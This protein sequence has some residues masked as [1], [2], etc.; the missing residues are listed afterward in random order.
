MLKRTR[1]I[2]LV[3]ALL[4]SSIL[5]AA[6]NLS[7][8]AGLN[9][10]QKLFFYEDHLKGVAK[11]S[12]L[13]YGFKS[14]TKDAES[15]TDNIEI[16]V[17]DVVDEGKRDLEFNFLSGSHHIDF[18]PTKAYTGN[19]PVI[20]HFLERDISRM[21]RD[22]GGSNGFFRNRIRDSF[23]NPIEVNGVKFQFHGQ[24]LDGTKVV[25]TPF[26]NN[27]YA[28]NFKLFVNKRYEF[29]FSDQIPGGIY[30]IRTQVPSDNGKSVL[31]EEDMT[32]RQIT[33]AI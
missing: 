29:I 33:P 16:R 8:P 27:P 18:S 3:P 32:F 1:I 12:R 4:F 20:I 21:A 25:V 22:T 10:A 15:F 30:S 24:A 17:T 2:A 19:N 6:T 13:D 23:K 11:N 26:V 5:S 31:I 9:S 7:A 14:V 28:E